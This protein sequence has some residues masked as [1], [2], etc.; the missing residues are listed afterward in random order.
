MSFIVSG[1]KN[2]Q[3]TA[4]IPVICQISFFPSYAQNLDIF[5]PKPPQG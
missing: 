4:T 5:G 1:E 3:V 2:Q